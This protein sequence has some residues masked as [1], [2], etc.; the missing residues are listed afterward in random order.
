MQIYDLRFIK[1]TTQKIVD[2]GTVNKPTA[3]ETK[4]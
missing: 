1:F 2:V 4:E 3:A